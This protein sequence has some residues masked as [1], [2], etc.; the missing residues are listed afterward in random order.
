MPF[1]RKEIDKANRAAARL[2]PYYREMYLKCAAMDVGMN[3]WVGD[4]W[5]KQ[6]KD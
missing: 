3:R 5:K 2:E 1:Y 4:A 6:A